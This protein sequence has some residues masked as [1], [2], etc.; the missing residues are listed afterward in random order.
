MSAALSECAV[1]GKKP[2]TTLLTSAASNSAYITAK[3]IANMV[4]AKATF[5]LGA[6]KRHVK[7][8]NLM[9]AASS[10]CVVGGNEPDT[11]SLRQRMN[12]CHE[13]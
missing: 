12:H 3:N 1:G 7:A 2:G 10:E 8:R 5:E 9:R 4:I 6:R 13:C 11:T